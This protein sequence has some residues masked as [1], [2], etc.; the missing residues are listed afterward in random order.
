[1]NPI[2]YALEEIHFR[3]PMDVLNV[4]FMGIDKDI[5]S[6]ADSLDYR[7][8]KSVLRGIVLRKLNVLSMCEVMI[9]LE[10]SWV[11]E[12]NRRV[13]ITIPK[14]VT[15]NK[16]IIAPLELSSGSGYLNNSN[17]YSSNPLSQLANQMFISTAPSNLTTIS[18]MTLI[19]DNT[20]LV[21]DYR[22]QPGLITIGGYIRCILE[23][24]E[25]FTQILTRMLEV[26]GKF[27]VEA[28]KAYIYNRAY[29]QMGRSY[30]ESGY[31]LGPIREIIEGY[32]QSESNMDDMM[33]N[34]MPVSLFANDPERMS[35]LIRDMISYR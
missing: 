24:D 16:S 34:L 17:Y 10:H 23:F 32:S 11:R 4:V 9:P 13:I 30:I 1:M 20:I 6:D 19:G 22:L 33:N 7:I 5:Y 18:N 2:K 8:T 26:F 29:I 31:D 3:I 27:C 21:N 35:L 12:E 25:N 28:C 15:G 14:Y